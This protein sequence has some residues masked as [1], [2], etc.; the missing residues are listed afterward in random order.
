MSFNEI[1]ALLGGPSSVNKILGLRD[2]SARD[3]RRAL[4]NNN[5]RKTWIPILKKYAIEHGNEMI[6]WGAK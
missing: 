1:C 2:K 3:V 4:A 6:K 5:P